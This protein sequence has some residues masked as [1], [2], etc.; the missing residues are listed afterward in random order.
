MEPN[1]IDTNVF[2]YHLTNNH[3]V[4]SPRCTALMEQIEAGEIIAVTAITAVD[5][6][7]R[8]LTKAFGRARSDAAHAL[9]RLMR[10]PEIGIDHREAVLDAID[11]WAKQSPLSFADCYHLALAYSLRMAAIY[12]YDRKMG[13]YPGMERIEP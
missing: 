6:T 3:P 2:V 12:T 9:T 7:L 11:F 13:R 4:Y 8:V 10:H 5:E 1:F